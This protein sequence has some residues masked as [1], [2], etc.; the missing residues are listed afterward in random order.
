[1]PE[2]IKIHA[3]LLVAA[4]LVAAMCLYGFWF[5]SHCFY[6]PLQDSPAGCLG[7]FVSGK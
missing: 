2:N 3:S 6:A 4:A 5:Y 1:M 7:S